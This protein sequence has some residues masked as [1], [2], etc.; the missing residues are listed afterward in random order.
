MT[1]LGLE[2]GDYFV[3]LFIYFFLDKMVGVTVLGLEV[4]SKAKC[5]I[6]NS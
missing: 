4:S 6:V 2:N 3:I 5:I 1:L